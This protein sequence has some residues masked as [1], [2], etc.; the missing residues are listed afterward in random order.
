MKNSGIFILILFV[1]QGCVKTDLPGPDLL[2][3]P[4]ELELPAGFPPPPIPE[5]NALTQNRVALGKIL[6]HDVRLSGDNSISCADCHFQEFAFADPN[7]VSIGVDDAVGV[8]NSPSLANVAY[9]DSL[10]WDGG[11]P[12]LEL[13]VLA[14]IHN[15]LEMNEHIRDILD[16]LH[17]DQHIQD[18][19]LSAYG[20]KLDMYVVTR[21][22]AAFERT[23]IS[24]NSRFDQY[25]YEGQDVFTEDELAGWELFQSANAQCSS[26]HSGF[27]FTN[28]SFENIGL[29]EEYTDAGRERITLDPADNGKFRVPGLRNV[30]VT[31]PY[32]HDGSVATLEDVVEL[33]NA[34]GVG[35]PNQSELIHPLNLS[36]LEKQQLVA[37]LKT[38]TDEEFIT[39]QAFQ[40]E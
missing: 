20:R 12:T 3:F 32:M 2:D 1:L 22:L 16:K 23:L 24:G 38:L 15:P 30:A 34:G 5:D 18:L 6:F 21:A 19:S 28:N 27:N 8:R 9:V 26:C 37:F 29:Y 17:D 33:I 7:P 40:V 4:Y 11:V 36:T 14:P 39:N 35:H 10:F 31:A 25:Y 13:Q